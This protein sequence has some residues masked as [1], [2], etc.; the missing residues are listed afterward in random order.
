MDSPLF[1]YRES[2]DWALQ[3][4]CSKGDSGACPPSVQEVWKRKKVY[5]D[6]RSGG[7]VPE[8]ESV[9]THEIELQLHSA[10]NVHI[11]IDMNTF[12]KTRSF[13]GKQT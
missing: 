8:S 7:D 5:D 13:T 9:H 10:L 12:R 11:D 2:S 6:R 4:L 3:L 1:C